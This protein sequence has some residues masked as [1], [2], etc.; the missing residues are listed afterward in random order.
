[1]WAGKTSFVA[2]GGQGEWV[3]AIENDPQ[4]LFMCQNGW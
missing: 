2:A 1:M 4:A 3:N